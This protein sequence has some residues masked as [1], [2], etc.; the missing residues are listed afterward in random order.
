MMTLQGA[1]PG[2]ADNPGIIDY[3]GSSYVFGFNYN[4][5]LQR[6]NQRIGERRSIC[7]E[8][9]TYN[10]DGTIPKLPSWSKT[11]PEQIEPLDPYVQTQAETI[12]WAWDVKTETCQ[13]GGMDVTAIENGDYIKV[14]G[15]D[16]GS[17]ASSLDVRVASAGNGGTIEVRLDSQTG[18]LVGSCA[19]SGTGG[20]QT[21]TTK[22]CSIDN[23]TGMHDLYFVFT[24]GVR[25]PVQLQLVEVLRF[26][27]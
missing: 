14:K 22:T 16:F 10:A 6:E 5:Q 18:R 2:L 7:V 26:S 17:G 9:M 20:G 23:A 8:K 19:V 15:A 24:G 4:V 12:A 25:Q 27:L 3:K 21:W 11:G 13:E 1:R